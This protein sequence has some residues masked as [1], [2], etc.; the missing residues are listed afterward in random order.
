M[1]PVGKAF[2]CGPF[3]KRGISM[4]TTLLALLFTVGLGTTLATTTD[5]LE[6]IVGTTTAT[7]VDGGSCTGSGCGSLTGVSDIKVFG[8]IDG[9]TINIVSGTSNSPGTF[10]GLDLSSETAT[11]TGGA[12][13]GTSLEVVY[14]D[15][16]FDPASPSFETGYS[17]TITGTGST[18]ESAYFDN[19]NTLFAETT[20]IG[21]VGPLTGTGGVTAVGGTASGGAGSVAPYSLTLD[22]LFTDSGS[23]VTFSVDGAVA[24]VPE[25]GAVILFGT[26]LVFCASKL[27][28][29]RL[30]QDG[31]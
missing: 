19:S 15:I 5:S 16:N 28:R 10:P 26:V 14:S 11:C 3:K 12:C 20:L 17:G 13:A 7:F 29:R 30:S 27:R 18:S 6:L 2:D 8:S 9:W 1:H 23:A 4:K 31:R 25:P 24:S 22:Q 21:T